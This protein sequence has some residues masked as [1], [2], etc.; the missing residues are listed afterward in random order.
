MPIRP[1]ILAFRDK[2]FFLSN[3][4][5]V[6][7]KYGDFTFPSVEHAY[8]AA[9]ST[10]WSTRKTISRMASAA[11]AK[12]FGR[13][14]QIRPDWDKVKLQVMEELLRIKFSKPMMRLALL[15]TGDAML[16]EGNDHRDTF[17]GVYRGYGHNHLGNILMKLRDEYTYLAKEDK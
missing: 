1:P 15:E 10:R 8:Q 6:E 3:F 11:A 4:Y 5:A 7:I 9:K 13:T 14:I 16:E 2:Y 17:W 12:R